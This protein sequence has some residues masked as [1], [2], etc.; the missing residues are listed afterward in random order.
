MAITK[1][2]KLSEETIKKRAETRRLK[3]KNGY[4]HPSK[5]KKLSGE[6]K[7]KRAEIRR[8]KIKNGY[9]SPLKGRIISEYSI[10]KWKETM[11]IKYENGYISP[12]KGS[13]H[14][15]ETK[16]K[17]SNS[18]IKRVE[19]QILNGMPGFPAVGKYET[20][21]INILE[22][23]FGY[24]ILRPYKVKGY[25]LDGYCPALNLA[26][27][28]DESHHNKRTTED[29]DRENIIKQELNCQFLRIKTTT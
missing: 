25:Y 22:K 21:T 13:E 19:R 18:G 17:M 24:T 20:N 26:I 11:R 10:K 29:L 28:V 15:K 9:I 5:N 23:N 7:R 16:D 6:T 8:L 1:G 14:S 4:V 27:E 2:K 12:R 3:I